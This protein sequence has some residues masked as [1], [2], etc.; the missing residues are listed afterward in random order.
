M[1]GLNPNIFQHE[2]EKA[3]NLVKISMEGNLM[4][5]DVVRFIVGEVVIIHLIQEDVKFFPLFRQVE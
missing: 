1:V 4:P 3:E 2:D 5:S